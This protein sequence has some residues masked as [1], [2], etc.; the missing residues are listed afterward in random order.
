MSAAKTTP[1][2]TS[3]T[4]A[5]GA[6]SR[7]SVGL[8][9]AVRAARA[10]RFTLAELAARANLSVGLLSL[11]ERGRSNPSLSTL[12]RLAESLD[13]SLADLIA[14]SSADVLGP[15]RASTADGTA[16]VATAAAL[17]A[18][19]VPADGWA[20]S[21][22]L[23][24]GQEATVAV[25]EGAL[26]LTLRDRTDALARA[27][28]PR[29]LA[30]DLSVR[31]IA[32]VP[33]AGLP[34]LPDVDDPRWIDLVRGETPFRPTSLPTQLLYT[35]VVRCTRQ[36][37]STQTLQHWIAQLRGLLVTEPL[38]PVEIERIFGG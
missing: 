30:V 25:H 16:E 15:D 6:P 12:V 28:D 27:S 37:P 18:I 21:M 29:P 26:E 4:T 10:G 19:P 20:S 24:G 35:H 14:A 23:R 1:T 9:A 3:R 36:D 13:L 5:S 22:T 33:T 34:E 32:G 8:G 17:P 38:P 31:P 7:V 2:V 11:V